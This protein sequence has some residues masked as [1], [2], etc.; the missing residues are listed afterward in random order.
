MFFNDIFDTHLNIYI[1]IYIYI[2]I[3]ICIYIYSIIMMSTRNKA[4]KNTCNSAPTRIYCAVR[5][6]S[7]F[8]TLN[9]NN[10][11]HIKFS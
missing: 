1:Y 5:E 2:Y 10:N 8:K 4:T 7:K 6:K 11:W 3:C 9:S